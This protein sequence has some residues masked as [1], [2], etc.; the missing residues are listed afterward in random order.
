MSE[1]V[2]GMR[3]LL[4]QVALQAT[5]EKGADIPTIVTVTVNP[6]IDTSCSISNVAPEVKL[7]C[8]EP[9]W[10]P[11]GGGINVARAIHLL[12]GN[13]V[14]YWTCGGP[15][16]LMLGRLLDQQGLNHRP[17]MIE[18]MTRENVVILETSTN[19]QYRFGMPGPCLS[20]DELQ[21]CLAQVRNHEPKPN[22]LVVSGSLPLGAPNDLYLQF[23]QQAPPHC[24]VVLD[25]SGDALR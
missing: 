16:G 10:D 6:A 2:G 19:H 21:Q 12:G 7:H 5:R 24:R 1:P 23:A 15:L 8:S 20:S 11:G 25:S 4:Q 3:E 9:R 18:G 22:Y 17:I 14:A 13:A